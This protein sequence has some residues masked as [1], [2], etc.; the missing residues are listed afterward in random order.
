[1][2]S[3]NT[4]GVPSACV[5]LGLYFVCFVSPGASSGQV[6]STAGGDI[7]GDASGG[8]RGLEGIRVGAN[9]SI[10][11]TELRSFRRSK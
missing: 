9:V 10:L 5:G 7:V 8:G 6:S 2:A 11:F 1:M 3:T 4:A